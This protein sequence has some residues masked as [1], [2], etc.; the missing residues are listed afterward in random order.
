[1][2]DALVDLVNISKSYDGQLILDDLN[3]YIRQ[4]EFL[5]LLGPSGCGKTT[6]LR[7]LGGF[8][9]PDKGQVIFE[10]QD[11]TQ[12]PPNKRNLNTVFQK[13]AL[14]PHMD[15]YDN[16]AFGLTL[17]K[18]PK[19]VI[20]QKVMRMLRLV[21]LE[22]YAD[23]NVTELSGG[24]QQRIAI[25]RALVNEPSVLLLDEPLGALDLKLRKEMQQE[26]K[27]IQQEV[28][29]TFIFVTHD[30]EEALT[31]SDK[32]VVMNAGEIQQIGTPTEIYRTPVNEF[33]AKFIGE[34][35]I[36]DGVMQGDDLV[37]FED[38]KFPCRARGFNKN[39]KVDVVIRPEHLDIVPRAEGMLKGV[40][41]SQLFKG[42]HYDTVVETR[43]G[44][45]ITVKM[46]VSQDRPVL[47][48][49]AGEK[50]SASA[51][52]IDVEDVGELDDAKVVALASAEAWDVETEEPISIKN[53]EYDI[54]PE[55]GSYSVTFT[56]AAGTSITVKAA[57]MAE[58]RVESKVYQEEIYAMN[59][60]KKVEDIQ[61]SI[62]L[63]TDLET[64][65]SASAWS[66]ED[67]EQVE[68]TD[69]KY[70][71]DPET[72]E[73]GVYD[74]TFSTEGYEY[75]VSTTRACEEGA[76]V[77]LIFR[78]EDIHVMK[79]EGQW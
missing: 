16:I 7:I 58:N 60:F 65:A 44:T 51:F 36:I 48:A 28:G 40:V 43:V 61:E 30:Q 23:R 57:V 1:M 2:K 78:P 45:T 4:N 72:I 14:F 77:G 67:G 13:Y 59:F 10:G 74:V 11:I 8:E 3:L 20:E 22:D 42:M 35:N 37:V 66:L 26:L 71:F 38:K 34:T 70:D 63:D 47:N 5:T 50:I 49:D 17:K 75:K 55:V 33:V 21:S 31:M 41:K 18:E 27:Y 52:L 64:W 32:I 69:V 9:K 73:P 56:T 25:A 19:D 76:E 79:K 62:A 46:Q 53:V 29:I 15:V 24:Q 6:T 12:L 54:K 68:I 39:E